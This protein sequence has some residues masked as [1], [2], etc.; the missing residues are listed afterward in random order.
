MQL[1]ASF[2]PLSGSQK[3][4]ADAGIIFGVSVITK[5]PALGH[6]LFVDDKTLDQVIELAGAG[7]DG[8]RVKL[9]HNRKDDNPI[10][11]TVGSLRQFRRD[12]D[13]VRADLHLLK[14]DEGY[15]KIL[16]MASKQP[17]D[18]GLSLSCDAEAEEKDGQKV[19]RLTGIDSVDFTEKPAANPNGLFSE[20]QD[21]QT[22]INPMSKAI[23]LAL[24]LP[25]TATEEEIAAKLKTT[26]EANKPTD[27]SKVTADIEAA[28][29]ELTKLTKAATDAAEAAKK[30]EIA[31]LV[32]EASRDGKVIPLTDVQLAA[33]DVA[34]IKEMI[35]K[36]PKAQVSLSR[37]TVETPK[38]SDGKEVSLSAF[39]T[40]DERLEFCRSKRT[41]G[42]AAINEL[43]RAQN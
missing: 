23:A 34:V 14:A 36:L 25:E 11:A 28:K 37:K 12:G 22:K 31:S 18:F 21:N 10:L 15:A 16:E 7:Q 3:V 24:S 35:S 5:G 32:A 6:G 1:S 4:D 43:I 19:I 38:T 20:K 8:V 29:L 13:A 30:A 39:K 41:E 27:L 33:M 2:A 42:I 17:R 9:K 26:L 40:A